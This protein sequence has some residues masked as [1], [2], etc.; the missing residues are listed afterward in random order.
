MFSFRSEGFCHLQVEGNCYGTFMAGQAAWSSCHTGM[1][2][3]LTAFQKESQQKL[4]ITHLCVYQAV[5]CR[6]V[7][8]WTGG[9]MFQMCDLHVMSVLYK[10]TTSPCHLKTLTACFGIWSKATCKK[11]QKRNLLRFYGSW[12]QCAG[13]QVSSFQDTHI[14]SHL[15]EIIWFLSFCKAEVLCVSVLRSPHPH[16]HI[17]L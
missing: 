15:K 16:V 6:C 13:N 11:R 14:L 9:M 4:V 2:P 5:A 1:L 10:S 8:V 7:W 17:C 12:G 3:V